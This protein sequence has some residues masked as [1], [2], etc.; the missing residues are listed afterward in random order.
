MMTVRYEEFRNR[1]TSGVVVF[2]DGY[3]NRV[4]YLAVMSVVE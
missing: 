2:V 4:K 3:D 1:G